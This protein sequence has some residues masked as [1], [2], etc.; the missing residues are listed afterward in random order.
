MNEPN[1]KLLKEYG[2]AVLVAIVIAIG[3]RSFVIEA[4]RIPS[5]A[6]KPTLE[7]GDTIFVSKSTYNWR[8]LSK[9]RL[10]SSSTTLPKRGDVVIF[11]TSSEPGRDFIK[12]VIGLPGD[13]VEIRES[14]VTLN[15]TPLKT[16][17]KGDTTCGTETLPEGK[18]FGTCWEPPAIENFGPETIPPD[19]IF[20]LCDLRSSATEQGKTKTWRVIPVSALKGQALWVW[21]SVD[22]GSFEQT[23][24][25]PQ[26][27][28]QRMFRRIE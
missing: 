25:F 3:I 16:T 27:R 7:A 10:G 19:S 24:I 9:I 17:I 5:S 8:W 11:S 20:V 18:T 1:Y 23:G 21:L 13:S 28:F 12:R 2:I 26:I 14:R 15:G 22:P 6:M 4:Y